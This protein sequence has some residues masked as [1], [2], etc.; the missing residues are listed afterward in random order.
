MID[1]II[2]SI[3]ASWIVAAII[4]LYRRR[5]IQNIINLFICVL[6]IFFCDSWVENIAKSSHSNS[7]EFVSSLLFVQS[8][9][10]P[11]RG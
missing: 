4:L 9:F 1:G 11:H 10:K 8:R 2:T 3:I 5:C 7:S 6:I